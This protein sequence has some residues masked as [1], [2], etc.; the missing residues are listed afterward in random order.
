MRARLFVAVCSTLLLLP[1]GARTAPTATTRPATFTTKAEQ[2]VADGRAETTFAE[3]ARADALL[4]P[5]ADDEFVF[6][7]TA[8]RS[9]PRTS[10]TENPQGPA[11][12]VPSPAAS[13]SFQGLGDDLHTIPPDTN[14]AVGPN[15][16]LSAL[17]THVRVH[18]KTGATISTATLDGFWSP[19]GVTGS[20]DPRTL[21]DPYANRWIMVAAAGKRGAGA[22]LLIAVS[23]TTDPSG[24]WYQWRIIV[25]SSGS[26]WG[27]FPTVGFNRNW[28]VLQANILSTAN[29]A[30]DHSGIYAFAK[31]SLYA[32]GLGNYAHAQ[33]GGST[34]VPV[35]T[36]SSTL[37]TMYLL[38]NWVG[39]AG[40][41]GALRVSTITG[42]VGAETYTA[43]V[44]FPQANA[45]WSDAPIND[46]DLA[47]QLGSSRRIQLNDS[48]ILSAIW[49]NGTLWAAHTVFLPSSTPNRSAVQWWQIGSR[50]EVVQRG[51]IDDANGNVFYAYPSMAVN[52][53]NDVLLGY[54]RFSSSQYASANYAMRSGNDALG[55]M[56]GDVVLKAGEAAYY[57]PSGSGSNRWGDYSG[58]VVDPSD[59]SSMWTIQEYAESPAD[60]WGTWWGKIVPPAP[61]G[62]PL[63]NV[64]PQPLTFEPRL[65]NTTSAAKQ[66]TVK[67]NGAAQLTVTGVS[68]NGTNA[69]EFTKV[70]D[71]CGGQTLW[72]GMS[73][74][75][76]VTFRPVAAG[77]RTATLSVSSTA[78]GSPHS[79]T[80]NGTGVVDAAAPVT[81][82]RTSD[83]ALSLG[84]PGQV[85]GQSSDDYTGVAGVI[86]RFESENWTEQ[87]SASLTCTGGNLSCSWGAYNPIIPGTYT[88]R[89]WAT[90]AIGNTESPGPTITITVL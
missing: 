50:G 37:S 15:H 10:A 17:N 23:K 73:C 41:F 49:R 64:S 87:K 81:S 9:A 16:V 57:R 3:A 43:G 75:V 12:D 38:E 53:N 48:R 36:Y 31:S 20:F 88:V 66:V 90:D 62:S 70:S 82:F 35:T 47:P 44:L 67:N 85:F 25:D 7:T 33:D 11:P 1:V 72:P 59:D 46:A 52:K 30:F 56:R 39:D 6:A 79:I 84:F 69:S 78:T 63:M 34:Q 55:T 2:R 22:S 61:S 29:D 5:P 24:G 26:L 80:L 58:A 42:P 18:S 32:G 54:S 45:P 19:V 60:R 8:G 13:V 40:G 51:R 27:D 77:A 74:L 14:G 4:K 68:I 86:V 89:A 71:A 28:V 65:V 83:G 21:Y 76:G